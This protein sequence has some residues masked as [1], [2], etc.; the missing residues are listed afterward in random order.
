MSIVIDY[1]E[2][3]RKS[4]GIKSQSALARLAW[5]GMGVNAPAYWKRLRNGAGYKKHQRLQYDDLLS[6]CKAFNIDIA[7]AQIEIEQLEKV[8][9][10]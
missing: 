5:P 3:K 2:K 6:L 8:A 1:I 7:R 4:A 9:A 10:E